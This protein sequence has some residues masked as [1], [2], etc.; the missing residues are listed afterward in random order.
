MDNK[1][2]VTIGQLFKLTPYLNTYL[3]TISKQFVHSES[4]TS[5][6]TITIVATTVNHQMEVIVV[7]VGKN[8]VDNVLLD[9][10]SRVNVVTVGL[11]QKLGLPPP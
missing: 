3:T 4:S 1:I 5:K 8:M 11:R 2:I 7:H 6:A 10:G 9:G